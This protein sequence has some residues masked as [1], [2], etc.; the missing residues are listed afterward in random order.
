MQSGLAV[1]SR[2]QGGQSQGPLGL[3]QDVA[4]GLFV[5]SLCVVKQVNYAYMPLSPKETTG[6]HSYNRVAIDP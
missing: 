6:M 3:H 2:L 4:K 1:C 5:G